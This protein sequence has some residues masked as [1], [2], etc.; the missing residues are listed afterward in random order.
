MKLGTLLVLLAAITFGGIAAYLAYT[1]VA[2]RSRHAPATN[3]VVASGPLDYGTTLSADNVQV[4]PWGAPVLPEGAFKSVDEL[5]KDGT[6]V[7]L[8][9]IERHEPILSARITPP[10]QPASLSG[11]VAEGMRAVS[12]NVDEVRGVAGFVRTGD[13]VDIVLTRGEPKKDTNNGYADVLLQDVKVLAV[14]QISQEKQD[15]ANVVKSVTVEVTTQQAQ[16]LILAQGVGALSLVLR[17]TGEAKA[18]GAQRVSVADLGQGEVAGPA[19]APVSAVPAPVTAPARK[20]AEVWTYH[21]AKLTTIDPNVY[22]EG[23]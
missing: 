13:R 16:K 12:I 11:L 21:G 7:V 20:L 19:V 18:E 9:P 14:G 6:R 15:K 23:L 17:Q 22:R 8:T 3:I 4:V 5:L 1:I 2:A 10:N